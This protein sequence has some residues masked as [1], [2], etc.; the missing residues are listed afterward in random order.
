MNTCVFL[1]PEG[2]L[3]TIA[4]WGPDAHAYV[5][6]QTAG[7]KAVLGAPCK[8]GLKH[9]TVWSAIREMPSMS[10]TQMK[11]ILP[12]CAEA[13]KAEE[14]QQMKNVIENDTCVQHLW[15]EL[16]NS[17]ENKRQKKH[18]ELVRSQ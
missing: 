1:T 17:R 14:F 3:S 9:C 4:D 13:V 11:S 5:S 10:H 12:H 16:E 2:V 7:I 15:C 18:N 8:M 6:S